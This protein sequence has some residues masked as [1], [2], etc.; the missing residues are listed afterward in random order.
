MLRCK[1]GRKSHEN[2]LSSEISG[3]SFSD[4]VWRNSKSPISA[5]IS[6]WD[7]RSPPD[8]GGIKGAME[9]KKKNHGIC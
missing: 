2:R 6:L 1:E 4:A 5:D 3:T 7:I 9:M 8:K